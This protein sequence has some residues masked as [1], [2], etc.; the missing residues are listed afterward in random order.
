MDEFGS[1]IRH[2]DNPNVECAPFLYQ[3]TGIT[4]TIMWSLVDLNKNDE[5][6][7]DYVYGIKVY[8]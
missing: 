3:A 6:M 8:L 5:L 2:S 7:R 1:A 4:Y